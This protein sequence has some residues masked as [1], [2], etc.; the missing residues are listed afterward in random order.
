MLRMTVM[1]SEGNGN[2]FLKMRHLK[3]SRQCLP[4]SMPICSLGCNMCTQWLSIISWLCF[5]GYELGKHT[6]KCMHD[7]TVVPKVINILSFIKIYQS[8]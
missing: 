6:K 3:L 2:S 4:V 7:N 1:T 5:S 8:V